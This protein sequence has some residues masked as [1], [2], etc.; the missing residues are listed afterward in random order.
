MCAVTHAQT[1]V[2]LVPWCSGIAML[3]LY[4]RT[5]V[6]NMVPLESFGCIY[7]HPPPLLQQ[8]THARAH[9]ADTSGHADVPPAA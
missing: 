1:A 5:P 3:E 4:A 2:G 6:L 8:P 9:T 7:A